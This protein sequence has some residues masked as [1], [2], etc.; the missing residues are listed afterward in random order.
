MSNEIDSLITRYRPK[1]W[2]EFIGNDAAVKSLMNSFDTRNAHQYL[3]TGASGCG[4]T[5]AARIMA[6]EFGCKRPFELDAARSNSV[7]D[8]RAIIEEL[9]YK[10]LTEDDTKIFIIDECH[11]L[12]K[13]AWNSLLKSIEEPPSHV[14]WIFCTT[15]VGRVPQ[16]IKTRCL[17]VDFKPLDI[18]SLYN[19]LEQI[20]IKEKYATD[21]S[22]IIGLCAEQA[23]GSPRQAIANLAKCWNAENIEDAL[24]LLR[25][26]GENSEAVDLARSLVEGKD[27]IYLKNI[28]KKLEGI[29]AESVRRIVLAYVTKVVM[30]KETENGLETLIPIMA[31][32]SQPFGDEGMAPVLLACLNICFA[33]YE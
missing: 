30:G 18:N 26:A 10:P 25:A 8:T 4:K 6:T 13:A 29:D 19:L 27:F 9:R 33:S 23:G 7:D 15:D 3:L 16:N 32:F 21:N 14:Y 17:T 2:D 28:I 22:D 12:S 1:T 20:C 11:M 5:T 24:L 31:A